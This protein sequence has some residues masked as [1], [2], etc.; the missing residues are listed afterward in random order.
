MAVSALATARIEQS[1]RDVILE[2]E[3]QWGAVHVIDAGTH[4]ERFQI[5]NPGWGVNAMVARD[6]DGDTI[7]DIAFAA[8]AS[9]REASMELVDSVS[10]DVKWSFTPQYGVFS[11]VAL[12]DV[13]G[14]G[15]QEMIVAG[16]NGNNY[17]PI[18][19]YDETTGALEWQSPLS[20]GNA[21]DPFYIST[22][23]I[24]FSPHLMDDAED[25]ILAGTSIYDGRITV[26][27]GLTHN[28]KLANRNLREWSD[29]IALSDGCVTVGLR[30]R[31]GAGFRRRYAT[32]YD[33]V[34]RCAV[35][36]LLR[37][38]WA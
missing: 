8:T 24:L 15:Q 9:Y 37:N 28:V 38:R 5:P 4:Q 29:A 25:I 14:D 31:W 32:Q 18:E 12:G 17:A 6:I 11:A 13:D 33:R 3:A 22:A 35:A 34:E 26:I 2:V 23:R 10:G 1:G 21:N 27:D 20:I 30:W 7:P 19:I 16:N 36:G